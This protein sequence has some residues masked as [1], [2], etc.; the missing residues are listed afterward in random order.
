MRVKVVKQYYNEAKAEVCLLLE[1]LPTF[2]GVSTE[3]WLVMQD[4]PILGIKERKGLINKKPI[5]IS[6]VM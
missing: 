4:G 3:Y 6:K 2:W 5:F 1:R